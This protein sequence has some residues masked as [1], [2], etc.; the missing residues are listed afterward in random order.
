MQ[1]PLP[2]F[3]RRNAGDVWQRL[4]GV[5]SLNNPT[6]A[7]AD[8]QQQQFLRDLERLMDRYGVD[9]VEVRRR[10]LG[11]SVAARPTRQNDRSHEAEQDR[12]HREPVI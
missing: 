12:V 3:M 6:R 7:R 9:A 5:V 11:N 2:Q 1:V 8:K 4:S 10:R